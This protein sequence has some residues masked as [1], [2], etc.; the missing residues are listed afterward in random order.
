[1]AKNKNPLEKVDRITK[2]LP[3]DITTNKFNDTEQEKIVEMVVDDARVDKVS[4]A[5]WLIR[6][7]LDVQHYNAEKPS[8]IEGL[9]KKEWQSDR[10]MGLCPAVVDTYQ[11]TLKATCWNPDTIYFKATE[12]N[13]IDNREKLSNFTKVIISKN[14]CDLAPEVDEHIHNRLVM[15]VS[16]FDVYWKIWYEWVDKKI[17]KKTKNEKGVEKFTGHR[18]ETEY[19]R[20]EQGV[21]ENISN[22]DD[23]LLPAYGKRIQ[24]LPHVIRV[25][26]KYAYEI[27]DE[28][29]RNIY[30]NVDEKF[31]EKLKAVALGKKREGL[32]EEEAN[33]LGI[34]DVTDAD[35]R[36]MPLDLYKWQGVYKKGKKVEKY[37]FIIDPATETFL[38]GKP[39]RKV[40]RTG[41]YSIKGGSFIRVPGHIRGKSLPHLIENP[42]NAFNTIWDQMRDFQYIQNCPFGFFK[43]DENYTKQKYDIMP[44]VLYPTDDPQ[45]VV[46]PNLQRSSAWAHENIRLIFEIIE[47][48]T[49][50]ASF[51]L[52]TER[53]T[54]GTATRDN[55]VNEKSQTRF[56][57]WVSRLQEDICD[58]LTSLI[59][60]YQDTIPSDLA[61][62]ILGEEGEKLFPNLT[63]ND[64]R[65]NYDV[66]MSPDLTAGSR[67]YERQMKLWAVQTLSQTIWTNPQVNPKGNW[68]L[69]ADAAKVQGIYNPERYLGPEPKENMGSAKEVEDEWGRFMQGEEVD[70]VPGEDPREHLAGHEKQRAE[71]YYKLPDEY[72][73]NFD[74]HLFKTRLQFM[75]FMRQ[76]Q[77]Q[78]MA[79]QLA[80][81]MIQRKEMGISNE[82]DAMMAG[83]QQTPTAP[84]TAPG[85][86]V[87]GGM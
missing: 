27:L 24:D 62:R 80:G 17:P 30:T 60:L 86:V 10:N 31:I 8:I 35:L 73:D 16:Y 19:K 7:V 81:D 75:N 64:L 33:Q 15:G 48:L 11:A 54:S 12:K 44:G 58:A 41:K 69:F 63:V 51:F 9:T 49:G 59:S 22:V 32:G 55:I 76:V 40:T 84:P 29:K 23:V 18:I 67:M 14:H 43:P 85:M 52:T 61:E 6:K 1:M 71:K 26:H 79:D 78:Q 28:G 21:M 39:L 50:A 13:D 66:H 82:A 74:Q 72:R 68:N 87:T 47:K 38:A 53:N 37:Q 34:E 83:G 25:L 45:N 4:A 42:I 36:A 65:G 56:G 77:A 46:F 3:P 2:R 5:D 70:L 57:I 20:F